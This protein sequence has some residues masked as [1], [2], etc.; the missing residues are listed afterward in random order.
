VALMNGIITAKSVYGQGSTFIAKIRQEVVDKT[1]I[2]PET[3]KNLQEF[4]FMNKQLSRGRLLIRS[5]MPY[6]KIL[7]VDD[8]MTN[9]DVMKGL[10]LPYG[11]ALDCVDSGQKAIEKIREL[12][13]NPDIPKYDLIFM[14]HMM[15][16][17]DGIEAVRIIRNEIGT[18]YAR[19]VPI[20]A[21]T[22]NALMGNESMFLANGFNAYISKPI[23]LMQLN[24]VL[25]TW[26]RNKQSEETQRLA[27]EQYAEVKMENAEQ[28]APGILDGLYVTGVDLRAGKERYNSETLYV[29]I[30]RSFCVHTPKMLDTLR[31]VSEETLGEYAVIVHGIKSSSY[32][33]CA[34]AVG[35]RAELLESAAKAGDLN[36]VRTSNGKFLE[37]IETLISDLEALLQKVLTSRGAKQRTDAPSGALL[38]RLLEACK[39]Y[40]PMLME[41]IFEELDKYEYESGADLI[42]WLR[43]QLDNLE[44][45]A[46]QERLEKEL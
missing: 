20:I 1:P 32:G 19:T 22:A 15:P 14:D 3:A 17:M 13:A 25:N 4:R 31:N 28:P 30:L 11:L 34:N 46:I 43:D 10:L 29:D 12:E 35:K 42:P 5:Y 33:I 8:V 41:E 27:E 18:E 23:N 2:G 26:V 40:K 45:E 36:M 24:M 16:R 38:A 9:L 37:S 44:Y 7:V 21:L 39:Q 6:G